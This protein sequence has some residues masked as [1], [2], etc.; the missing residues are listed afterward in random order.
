MPVTETRFAPA[1]RKRNL[2]SLI[3]MCAAKES[4]KMTLLHSSGLRKLR[5]RDIARPG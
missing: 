4:L 3:S 2:I 5:C 1:N